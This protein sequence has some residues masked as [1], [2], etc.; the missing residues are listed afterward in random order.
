[1]PKTF[2]KTKYCIKPYRCVSTQFAR[3]IFDLGPY[4][5]QVIFTRSTTKFPPKFMALKISYN[6]RGQISI[7]KKHFTMFQFTFNCWSSLNPLEPNRFDVKMFSLSLRINV[8]GSIGVLH[9]QVLCHAFTK[10]IKFFYSCKIL[11]FLFTL[12]YISPCQVQLLVNFFITLMKFVIVNERSTNDSEWGSVIL[13]T[14]MSVYL[15]ASQSIRLTNWQIKATKI[16]FYRPQ[17]TKEKSRVSH[18]VP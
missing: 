8:K 6:R 18:F 11:L 14:V 3:Q 5:G 1:M 15:A 16:H 17:T 10:S 13:M 7:T 2:W 12:V 9:T 4:A